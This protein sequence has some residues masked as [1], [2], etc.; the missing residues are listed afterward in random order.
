MTPARTVPHPPADPDVGVEVLLAGTTVFHG[1]DRRFGATAFNP[2]PRPASRFSFFSDPRTGL[3]V[4]T[5]YGGLTEQVAIAESILH[6]V[7]LAGGAV[8]AAQVDQ[9]LVSAVSVRRD[10][11]LAQLHSAGLRRLGLRA[12]QITDTG[13]DQYPHTVGW[14]AAIHARYVDVDGLIWTSNRW[15]SDPALV[16]FGDRVAGSDI[17]T[18]ATASRDFRRITDRLWLYDLL[19]TIKV[20]T[21]ALLAR[22]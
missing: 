7:P 12:Q 3:S 14:A 21:P 11:R 13:P 2:G 16:L 17:R 4:P 1:H 20:A 10:L 9:R 22:P 18:V 19:R 8:T 6:D 5:F 15:N